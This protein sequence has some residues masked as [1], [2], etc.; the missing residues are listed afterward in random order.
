VLRDTGCSTVV[1]KRELVDDEQMTGGTETC[2]LTVRLCMGGLTVLG[3]GTLP[4]SFFQIV[5]KL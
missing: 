3:A 4:I 1:V 2:I 5:S